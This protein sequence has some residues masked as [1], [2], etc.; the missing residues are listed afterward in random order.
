MQDIEKSKAEMIAVAAPINA[1]VAPR[2]FNV[3]SRLDTTTAVE[4]IWN[5]VDG[6]TV[7]PENGPSP[8]AGLAG[9][10]DGTV[11]AWSAFHAYCGNRHD[12]GQASDHPNLLRHKE[13]LALIKKVV[14]TGK[15]PKPV[16]VPRGRVRAKQAV[17]DKLDRALQKSLGR[18]G[19]RA[20][21]I[22][23]VRT[24]G[25]GRRCSPT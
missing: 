12:L 9:P 19:G 15:L 11:P 7:D 2:F 13:V 4:L 8:V 25:R 16:S 10:G 20:G 1:N 21:S 24:A 5:D 14:T 23:A 3:R 22:R 6:D 18:T 17:R